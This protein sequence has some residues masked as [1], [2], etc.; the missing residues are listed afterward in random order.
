MYRDDNESIRNRVVHGSV[1]A[2]LANEFEAG[3]FESSYHFLGSYTRQAWRHTLIGSGN[4]HG[5]AEGH[6]FIGIVS[7]RQ[8]LSKIV[9][10]FEIYRKGFPSIPYGFLICI[11]P[12][13]A[14]GQRRETG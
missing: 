11:T 10:R 1:A 9:E 13:D 2:F 12:S 14:S 7:V 5:Y 6:G 8:R 4:P 3:L